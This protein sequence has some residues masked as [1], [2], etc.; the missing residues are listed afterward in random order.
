VNRFLFVLA[1]VINAL[2]VSGAVFYIMQG[3]P[4]WN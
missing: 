3:V 2:A 1:E 4:T